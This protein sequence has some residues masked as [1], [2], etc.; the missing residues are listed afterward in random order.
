MI[1]VLSVLA[2]MLFA[3]AGCS[4]V[5]ICLEQDKGVSASDD[6]RAANQACTPNQRRSP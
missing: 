4:S 5:S 2:L 1:R 6:V 3:T